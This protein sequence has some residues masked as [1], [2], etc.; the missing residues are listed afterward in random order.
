MFDKNICLKKGDILSSKQQ[1]IAITVNTVGV[2]G[3][4]LAFHF[5]CQFP[6]IDKDYRKLCR[7]KKLKMGA[8]YLYKRSEDF[9]RMLMDVPYK[10]SKVPSVVTENGHRWFLLFPTKNHWRESSPILGIEKGLKWLVKNYQTRGIKSLALPALGCGLGG[11]S[12]QV[13][14]PLMCKYLKQMDIKS[15]IYLPLEKEIPKEHLQPEFLFNKNS[16]NE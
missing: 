7:Q 9:D 8:P 3:K 13:V 11:L 12:W 15:E 16:T 4:G 5:K 10:K 2:M 1:T 6:D 14:G